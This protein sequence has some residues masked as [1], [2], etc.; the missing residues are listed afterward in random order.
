MIG[1][2]V[3]CADLRERAQLIFMQRTRNLKSG[4]DVKGR[5]RRCASKVCAFGSRKP[6]TTRKPRRT[7]L[8]ASMVQFQ[9]ERCTH[10][11]RMIR[12]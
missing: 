4:M 1:K 2:G 10:T 5:S 7:E 8:S 12:P 11:G 3:E 6:C 9:S